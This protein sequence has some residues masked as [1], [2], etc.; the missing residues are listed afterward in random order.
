VGDAAVLG[1]SDYVVEAVTLFTGGQAAAAA[2][3][4]S[5]I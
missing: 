5:M 3:S 4:A 2:S 1:D